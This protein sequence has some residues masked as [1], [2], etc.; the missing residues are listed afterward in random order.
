LLVK[1]D[2]GSFGTSVQVAAAGSI[3]TP[4]GPVSSPVRDA[5]IATTDVHTTT[6]ALDGTVTAGDA[7]RVE[8]TLD[9][10]ATRIANATVSV[11][12]DA[13]ATALAAAIRSQTGFSATA[14]G[15]VITV[16]STD[17]ASY[18]TAVT[19]KSVTATATI[20]LTSAVHTAQ[21]TLRGTIAVGDAWQIALAAAGTTQFALATVTT[22]LDQLAT[23]LAAA[24]NAISGYAASASGAVVTISSTNAISFRTAV[25]A[26]MRAYTLALA[27]AAVPGE[28]WKVTVAG[29][30]HSVT[31]DGTIDTLAKVADALASAIR[32]DTLLADYTAAAKGNSIV[33][34]KLSAGEFSPSLTVTAAGNLS[35]AGSASASLVTLAGTPVV[36]DRWTVTLNG[37][38]YFVP[39]S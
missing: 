6:I 26:N 28:Q 20:A 29:Q 31:V 27:G 14:A 25:N 15:A 34:V 4:A 38:P 17:G 18:T 33:V 7:W 24:D 12:L 11:G 5:A 8:L 30:E 39:V 9:G 21:V 22:D 23:N 35:A 16:N 13:L 10:G 2:G 37:T 1:R 36:G 32:S 19:R 3:A